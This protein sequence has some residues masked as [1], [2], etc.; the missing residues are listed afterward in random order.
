MWLFAFLL[1]IA[2]WPGALDPA[3]VLRWAV[4]AVGAALYIAYREP[5]LRAARILVPTLLIA[6]ASVLWVPDRLF[7]V[8]D[9]I[10]LA[11]L[12]VVFTI[13]ATEEDLTPAWRGLAA[14]VGVSSLIAIMQ[15]LGHS[16]V[17]QTAA[18]AGLFMNKNF[19]AEAGLVALVPAIMLRRPWMI[20]CAL[21]AAVLP[22]SRAVVISGLVVGGL[23]FGQRRPLSALTLLFLGAVGISLTWVLSGYNMLSGASI[24][25]RLA[26]WQ[27]ALSNMTQLGHGLGS[28]AADFPNVRYAHSELIQALYEFGIFAGLPIAALIF[29]FMERRCHVEHAMLAAISAIALFSFPF[30]M[31]LTGFAAALA[32][33]HLAGAGHRLRLGA[34]RGRVAAAAGAGAAHAHC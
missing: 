34:D 22:L 12:T 32:A 18:P 3:S 26:F 30:H 1:S 19:L 16:P 5:D 23:M 31:P 14:G 6:M 24:H 7:W 29:I 33:G 21:P 17:E 10:H 15:A 25:E 28:Y 9:A 4:L 8:D 20:V 27:A 2:F 11:I 13:G